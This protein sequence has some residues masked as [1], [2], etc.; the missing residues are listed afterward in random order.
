MTYDPILDHR[1]VA[2]AIRKIVTFV[3]R[4]PPTPEELAGRCPDPVFCS[5]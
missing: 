2:E 4:V 5:Q 1:T 3:T